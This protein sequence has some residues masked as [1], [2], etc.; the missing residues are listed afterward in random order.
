MRNFIILSVL[1]YTV[2]GFRLN[3][4]RPLG[5]L[6]ASPRSECIG[7]PNGTQ[8][9]HPINCNQF[10]LCENNI[11]L[12]LTCRTS[13]PHFDRCNHRCVDDVFVCMITNCGDAPTPPP[14]DPT[15]T[16]VIPTAPPEVTTPAVIPTAPPE[17]TTPGAP[18][19]PTA[20]TAPTEEPTTEPE[21]TT[22]TA[23]VIPTVP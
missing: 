10:I 6:H 23:F 8:L 7:Q 21:V 14:V 20:P 5:R 13:H 18:P 3:E 17:E 16:P 9:P 1:L 11:G 12:T 15:T 4:F 2:S 22:T 19:V